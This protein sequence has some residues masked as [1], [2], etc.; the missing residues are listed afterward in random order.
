MKQKVP[1]GIFGFLCGVAAAVLVIMP[2][3]QFITGKQQ[4]PIPGLYFFLMILILGIIGVF[5]GL[6]FDEYANAG[7]Q[8]GL[9][10]KI[11]NWSTKHLSFLAFANRRMDGNYVVYEVRNLQ[12][13]IVAGCLILYILFVRKHIPQPYGE[14]LFWIAFATYMIGEFPMANDSVRSVSK[15]IVTNQAGKKEIWYE[16]PKTTPLS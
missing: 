10:P 11:A 1:Y 13:F 9:I 3:I 16:L 2:I 7:N 4:N 8:Q 5:V 15:K 12:N 14:T 6:K